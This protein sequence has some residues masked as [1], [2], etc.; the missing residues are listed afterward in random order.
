MQLKETLNETDDGITCRLN[1]SVLLVLTM[2]I[3]VGGY[4]GFGGIY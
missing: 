3:L 1:K 4:Q 2:R